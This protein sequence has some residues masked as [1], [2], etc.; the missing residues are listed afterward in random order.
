VYS[1]LFNS[2]ESKLVVGVSSSYPM[3][4]HV[5]DSRI[6][7]S[8]GSPIAGQNQPVEIQANENLRLRM[9]IEVDDK[10]VVAGNFKLQYA[11]RT[12]LTCSA[13]FSA[14]SYADI[15]ESSLVSFQVRDGVST[16]DS[17]TPSPD[18]P[19]TV[20]GIV[21]QSYVESN[22]FSVITPAPMDSAVMF[23]FSIK[24]ISGE[25]GSYCFRV[26]R[27]GGSHLAG[28]DQIPELNLPP[29]VQQFMRHGKWF[30]TGGNKRPYYWVTFLW[31]DQK[32][33]KETDRR[34]PCMIAT[35]PQDGAPEQ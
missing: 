34:R 23:D 6:V 13:D 17:F 30:D 33:T 32:V 8:L 9:L 26:V 27:S 18:D 14:E 20:R 28:Y 5:I 19:T 15:T 31:S 21:R 35:E 10:N 2:D 24:D 12:G 3:Y 1:A 7:N 4:L 25:G 11:P 16:G 29:R 22:P